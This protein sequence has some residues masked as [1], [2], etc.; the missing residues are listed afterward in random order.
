M[1]LLFSA[2]ATA[3]SVCTEL[4]T[5]TD[6]STSIDA[7]TMAFVQR[8]TDKLNVH[9]ERLEEMLPCLDSPIESK[10]S[11][12][13]HLTEGLYFSISGEKLKAQQSF[14]IS[15]AVDSNVE[16]PDYIY[17]KG[18]PIQVSFEN[19][20]PANRKD[21]SANEGQTWYFDGLENV[22]RPIDTPTIFQVTE[23]DEVI[24]SRYLTPYSDLSVQKRRIESPKENNARNIWLWT[25]GTL[26]SAGFAGY[27]QNEYHYSGTRPIGLYIQNQIFFGAFGYCTYKL[28]TELI[29]PTHKRGDQ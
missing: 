21:V 9:I 24:Y 26:V 13:F 23:K 15:K 29:R 22:G 8:D 27:T 5:T 6:F 17:P 28:A 2:A 25:A 20:P 4:H 14:A 11:A 1:I 3:Q 10:I 19:T 12:R 18:H 16:F 7:A